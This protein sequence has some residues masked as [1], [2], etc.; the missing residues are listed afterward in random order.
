MNA[1]TTLKNK[2]ISHRVS[3]K[4]GNRNDFSLTRKQK[5]QHKRSKMYYVL[6]YTKAKTTFIQ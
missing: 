5:S 3:A 1:F 2:L 4:T 6:I